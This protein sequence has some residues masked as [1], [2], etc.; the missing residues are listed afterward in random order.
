MEVKASLQSYRQSPR[1]VRL[2]A[3][4]IRGRQVSDALAQLD[5]MVKRGAAPMKKLLMSAVANAENN[6]KLNKDSLMVK[7]VTVNAG[8]TMKR[9]MPRAFGRAYPIHKRTSHISLTL[10]EGKELGR[11][12]SQNKAR[13]PSVQVQK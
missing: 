8:V 7:N 1:K 5:L 3:D 9:S 4:A 12:A 10:D 6:F 2:I 11:S 13:K